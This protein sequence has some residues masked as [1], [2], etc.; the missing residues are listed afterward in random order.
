MNSQINRSHGSYA[1]QNDPGCID[2][3]CCTYLRQ[4]QPKFTQIL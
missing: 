2:D 4:G 1:T 3:H